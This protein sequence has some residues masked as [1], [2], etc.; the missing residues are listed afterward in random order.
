MMFQVHYGFNCGSGSALIVSEKTYHDGQWHSVLF[1]RLH[2]SGRLT[3]DGEVAGEG[4]SKG[5]TKSINILS[6]YYIGGISP[7]I[8]SDARVNIK[9]GLSCILLWQLY[10]I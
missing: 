9:V 4:S 6:P 7:N 5:S 10:L 1:S 3:I 8:S 2:T